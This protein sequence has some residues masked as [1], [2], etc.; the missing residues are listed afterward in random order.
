MA[1]EQRFLDAENPHDVQNQTVPPTVIFSM[2]KV[3]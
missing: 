3:G 2:R 1:L